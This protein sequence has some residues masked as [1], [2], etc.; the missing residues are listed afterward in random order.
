[1]PA[2]LLID[3][4][5][6]ELELTE[7]IL[8]SFGV[9]VVCA[10]TGEEAMERLLARDFDLV[11]T[12]LMMPGMNGYEVA[13][14]IRGLARCRDLP[15]L[16]LTAFDEELARALPGRPGGLVYCQ[17]PVDIDA[18]RALVERLMPDELPEA[19]GTR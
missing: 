12:D 15:I 7:R 16:I 4:D 8:R 2:I 17:K 6:D 10:E 14:T 18:L 19:A 3:D 13:S 9:E 11:I 1:M 5:P